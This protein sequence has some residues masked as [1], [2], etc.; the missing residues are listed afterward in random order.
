MRWPK[1]NGIT[2]HGWDNTP[3]AQRPED[4]ANVSAAPI[5]AFG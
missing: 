3:V 4:R 2:R 5:S 1:I